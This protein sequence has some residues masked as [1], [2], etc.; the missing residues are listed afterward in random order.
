MMKCHLMFEDFSVLHNVFL[1]RNEFEAVITSDWPSCLE[2]SQLSNEFAWILPWNWNWKCK[3]PL[4]REFVIFHRKKD[5]NKS[6]FPKLQLSAYFCASQNGVY[7]S[8]NIRECVCIKSSP[9]SHYCTHLK[10][11]AYQ[12]ILLL[13]ATEICICILTEFMLLMFSIGLAGLE[14]S[15]AYLCV[16]V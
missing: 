1:Q 4:T 13:C 12:A 6:S 2:W 9:R 10:H 7:G 5:P 11:V 3:F 16:C 15:F 8:I 14:F